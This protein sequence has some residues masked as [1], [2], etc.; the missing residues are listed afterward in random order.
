MISMLK[1]KLK[2]EQLN[3]IRRRLPVKVK[4]LVLSDSQEMIVSHTTEREKE[5][6]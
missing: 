2:N 6:Q 5:I 3:N 1:N 4:S